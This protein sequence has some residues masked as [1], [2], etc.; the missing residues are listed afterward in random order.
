MAGIDRPGIFADAGTCR[1]KRRKTAN[2]NGHFLYNVHQSGP[3]ITF[4]TIL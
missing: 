4:R 2:D 1:F 3:M